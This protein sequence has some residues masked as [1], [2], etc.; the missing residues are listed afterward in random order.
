[1][2]K[3]ENSNFTKRPREKGPFCSMCNG[4]RLLQVDETLLVSNIGP[5]PEKCP[6]N[7]P[8][9]HRQ[10]HTVLARTSLLRISRSN[11][12]LMGFKLVRFLSANLTSVS[13]MTVYYI[14]VTHTFVLTM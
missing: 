11:T 3:T 9:T 5:K 2:N 1:M 8:R 12:L 13:H 14:C 7:A 4:L 10:L 6:K